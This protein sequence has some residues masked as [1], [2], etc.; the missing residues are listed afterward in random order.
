MCTHISLCLTFLR[1]IPL[2]L[3]SYIPISYLYLSQKFWNSSSTHNVC[4]SFICLYEFERLH[5]KVFLDKTINTFEKTSVSSRYITIYTFIFQRNIKLVSTSSMFRSAYSFKNSKIPVK[6]T[7]ILYRRMVA[8][9]IKYFVYE[10][11]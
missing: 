3:R 10:L 4:S 11:G 2:L 1:S 7:C 6:T 9:F 5:A 8:I